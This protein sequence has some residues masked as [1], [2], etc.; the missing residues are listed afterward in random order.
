MA[1]QYNQIEKYCIDAVTTAPLHVGSASG[2]RSEVLIHPMTGRPFLQASGLAG[3][4]RAASEQVNV[5][6]VTEQLFGAK[7]ME[8]NDLPGDVGS[9]IKISDGEF[10]ENSIRMEYRPRVAI[11]SRTGSV[12]SS[13]I[14]GSGRESGHKFEME[15]IGSGAK[16]HMVIYLF[17]NKSDTYHEDFKRVLA[18]L[19][20][21]Y[22]QM[23]GQRSNGS[24]FFTAE[25]LLHISFDLTN[26]EGRSQWIQ[27]DTIPESA[28]HDLLHELS[29]KKGSLY[30]YEFEVIG[31]TEGALLVKSASAESF[32]IGAADTENMKNAANHYIIPGSSLKGALRNRILL[33]A[34]TL[35]KEALVPAMFG[36]T[37]KRGSV[38]SR[39]NVVVRD[40]I[41]G[42]DGPDVLTKLQSRIHV[43]KF[44]GGVMQTGL[45]TEKTVS[46]H[47]V[48]RIT[49]E[50]RGDTQASAGMI[51]LALR[52]LASGLWNLGSG[53]NVGRGF[54]TIE[55]VHMRIPGEKDVIISFSGDG[56][57]TD[58]KE[59]IQE[60]LRSVQTWGGQ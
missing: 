58:E 50:K 6:D 8:A 14:K 25:K 34:R 31:D 37:G 20:A 41:I 52:D 32:G 49:V 57:I 17:H 2:S 1:D 35:D 11:D 7:Q 33:I 21:G 15:L 56:N 19:T 47:V 44:T 10:L 3:M 26:A 5:E 43:D 60:V 23:G 51:L 40:V 39:G 59:R 53:Y 38:G 22:L 29:S 24:G 30:A 27:E 16:F 9:R 36:R 13:Q 4:L 46:G 28:Y 45:F 18:E 55:K 48:M 54:I 12:H 42:E